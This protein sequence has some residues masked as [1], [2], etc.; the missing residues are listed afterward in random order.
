M[1]PLLLLLFCGLLLLT[2]L[3]APRVVPWADHLTR[4]HPGLRAKAEWMA[5]PSV[6]EQ[7]VM[8]YQTAQEALMACA[9]G[10]WG[11]FAERLDAYTAGPYLSY[12]RKALASLVQARNP[13]LAAEFSAEHDL[14]VRHFTSDGLRCLLVDRQT[15]RT[16]TTSSYWSG[17][18]LHCQQLDDRA[19]VF[20]MAYDAND[21]RWKIEKLIQELPLGWGAPTKGGAINGRV[22]E[23][24]RLPVAAGRDD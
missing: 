11:K 8:D 5:P 3:L 1:L 10:N 24:V 20:Q 2:W 17:R 23:S 9:A 18:E 6:V 13:R 12:Q 19:F 14:T 16:V 4:L 15:K 7:V 21:K 22:Q